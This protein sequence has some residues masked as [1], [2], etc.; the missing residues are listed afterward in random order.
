MSFAHPTY[1][2]RTNKAKNS[3]TVWGLHLGS[4]LLMTC[5]L[6]LPSSVRHSVHPYGLAAQPFTCLDTVLTFCSTLG[7]ESAALFQ[8]VATVAAATAGLLQRPP[9]GGLSH[10]DRLGRFTCFFGFSCLCNHAVTSYIC[11]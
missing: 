10:N 6:K 5:L 2:S 9:V 1:A 4:V 3:M 11:R 8:A 7:L